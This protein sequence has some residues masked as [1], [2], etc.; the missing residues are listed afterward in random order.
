MKRVKFIAVPIF[1]L[2]FSTLN[3]FSYS[4][5]NHVNEENNVDDDKIIFNSSFKRDYSSN[6]DIDYHS[7]SVEV[8]FQFVDSYVGEL[9]SD[10]DTLTEDQY[11]AGIKDHYSALNEY[12]IN[13]INLK[14]YH[15]VYGS[16]YSPY[17]VYSYNS[18]DTLLE[19]DDYDK[20]LSFDSDDLLKIEINDVQNDSNSDY[21]T[22][23]NSTQSKLYPYEKALKDVGIDIDNLEYSGDGIKIGSIENGM[24][25]D[26]SNLQNVTYYSYNN[27]STEHAFYTSSIYAGNNGIAKDA[28]I[29]FAQTNKS[30]DE[31]TSYIEIC[32]W[33]V[34]NDV[35]VINQSNGVRITDFSGYGLN[36]AYCDYIVKKFNI[37]IVCS[38]GNGDNTYEISSPANALNVITVGSIDSNFALSQFSCINTQSSNQGDLNDISPKPTLVA[39]G[40]GLYGIPNIDEILNGTSFSAPIVTGIIALLMEEFPILKSNPEAVMSVLIASSFPASGQAELF[41]KKSG[42]GIVNY[43][44]ARMAAMNLTTSSIGTNLNSGDTI[45]YESKIVLPGQTLKFSS[46]LLPTFESYDLNQYEDGITEYEVYVKDNLGQSVFD[47]D[48]SINTSYL[49]KADYTNDTNDVQILYITIKF[50]SKGNYSATEKLAVSSFTYFDDTFDVGLDSNLSMGTLINTPPTIVWN[51]NYDENTS[52]FDASYSL[53]F[54][55]D[56]LNIVYQVDDPTSNSY[57]LRNSGAWNAIKNIESGRYYYYICLIPDNADIL[58]LNSVYY[59]DVL[60]HVLTSHL[61]T[62]TIS[63]DDY[64]F[65]ESYG[66]NNGSY[67]STFNVD[68]TTISTI[69]KRAGYFVDEDVVS[70]SAIRINCGEA[71]IEYHIQREIYYID[72]ELAYWSYQEMFNSNAIRIDVQY[73]ND[74]GEWTTSLDLWNWFELSVGYNNLKTYR[75]YFPN[76]TNDFK[77]YLLAKTT[78]SDENDFGRLCVGNISLYYYENIIGPVGPG[79][80]L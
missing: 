3:L 56:D 57:S 11:M 53:T 36:S 39:P 19:S 78:T 65:P 51:S 75:A 20:I 54:F 55:D 30:I 58:L 52:G 32:D 72:L 70:L 1:G 13:Q 27:Y 15:D 63:P 79:V 5:Y 12:R 21:S 8:I 41:N 26:L 4:F 68:G 6:N 23:Q 61:N 76:G 46:V 49:Y 16:L 10:A 7:S 24:P 66:S 71:F 29:Y 50:I 59:S 25:N 38:A 48:D 14:D 45:C 2:I 64:G 17:I 69:R 77:I 35:D 74:E 80:L 40:G 62:M 28:S 73:L 43:E 34:S 67:S 18:L 22:D 60:T 44:K 9:S 33:L 31:T 47:S 42:F 37:T